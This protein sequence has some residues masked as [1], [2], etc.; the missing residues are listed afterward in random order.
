V[1]LITHSAVDK[2]AWSYAS[3]HL[4]V[5]MA[6]YEVSTGRILLFASFAFVGLAEV[7]K[8]VNSYAT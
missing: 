8:H 4:Y 3:I 7:F 2:N 6:W 5:F 1:K